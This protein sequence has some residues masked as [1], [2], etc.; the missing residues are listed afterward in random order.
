MAPIKSRDGSGPPKKDKSKRK[1]DCFDGKRPLNKN[2]DACIARK[3]KCIIQP[4]KTK[5]D[6]CLLKRPNE[7]CISRL[8]QTGKHLLKGAKSSAISSSS[9]RKG[10]TRTRSQP[11]SLT[12]GAP[13]AKSSPRRRRRSAVKPL[14]VKANGTESAA[15]NVTDIVIVTGLKPTEGGAEP[16]DGNDTAGGNVTDV[17]G[18]NLTDAVDEREDGNDNDGGNKKRGVKLIG[19]NAT[20]GGD[21]TGGNDKV[22]GNVTVGGVVTG[23]NVTDGGNEMVIVG[24]GG[25]HTGGNDKVTGNGIVGV[26]VTGVNVTDGVK[27]MDEVQANGWGKVHEKVSTNSHFYCRSSKSPKE[28]TPSP[29]VPTGMSNPTTT[30]TLTLDSASSPLSGLSLISRPEVR[31]LYR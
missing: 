8:S 10:A 4:G 31:L 27:E 9:S 5:C 7:E 30:H 11:N 12:V 6:Y 22:T 2:C 23:G 18:G 28:T 13:K 14:K 24:D 29:P 16:C 26:H 21:E 19:G 25:D 17:P 3:K 15:G 1:W 20:D